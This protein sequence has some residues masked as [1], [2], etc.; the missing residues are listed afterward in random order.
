LSRHHRRFREIGE[1]AI[2]LLPLIRNTA[3]YPDMFR[4]GAFTL[5]KCFA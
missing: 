5:T 1:A 2:V 3:T 4:G